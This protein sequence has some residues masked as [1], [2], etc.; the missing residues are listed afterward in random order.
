MFVF[1]IP[2]LPLPIALLSVFENQ[3]EVSTVASGV[4]E[5]R[6]SHDEAKRYISLSMPVPMLR[7]YS[8]DRL[9]MIY[10]YIY[11][12]NAVLFVE[13]AAFYV[14]DIEIDKVFFWTSIS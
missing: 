2:V 6:L 3:K 5:L 1:P 4:S 8:S 9:N 12:F 7:N 14:E 13:R 11:L 10:M